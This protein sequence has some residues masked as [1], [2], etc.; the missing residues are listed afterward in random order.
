MF[1]RE[2]FEVVGAAPA[3]CRWARGWDL[4]ATAEQS[5]AFTAG[6][7]IGKT[8]DGF[9]YIA[10]CRRI[11]GSAADVERLLVSTASQDGPKTRGSIPQDPGQSGKSQAQ[12]LIRQLAGFDYHSSPESGDKATR[13]QPLAAQSEAGNVKIVRGDWNQAFLDEIT[14]FPNG[15]WKDQVDA[16]TRAFAELTTRRELSTNTK[17]IGGLI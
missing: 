14:T 16:A 7:K 12:Y 10:D 11:Q 8:P 5:A 15:K 1:K 9:F 6:V 3:N 4:A 17:T 2:W 13:A